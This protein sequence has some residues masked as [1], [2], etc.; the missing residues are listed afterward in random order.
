MALAEIELAPFWYVVEDASLTVTLMAA[1]VDT[2]KLDVDTL[3][4][5]PDTP[6]EAGPDRALDAPPPDPEGWVVV[7][8]EGGE[9]EEE[10]AAVPHAAKT[11]DVPSR[12][13]DV[14]SNVRI[15][16]SLDPFVVVSDLIISWRSFRYRDMLL[17]NS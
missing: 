14:L 3:P 5:V 8:V 7:E 4:T 10:V 11:A 6:P 15:D 9:L 12:R 1:T 13:K 17:K 16:M 2:M